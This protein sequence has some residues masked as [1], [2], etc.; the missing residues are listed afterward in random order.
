[1]N[2]ADYIGKTF[3]RLR[4]LSIADQAT[5]KGKNRKVTCL[6]VCG[7]IIETILPKLKTGH[8]KSCG[9]QRVSAN[10]IKS[11]KHGMSKHALDGVYSAMRARC[12]NKNNVAYKNYGGRGISVCEEWQMDRNNFFTWAL[13]NGWVHGLHLDRRDNDGGY[14]PDNCRFIT[15]TENNRNKKRKLKSV[16]I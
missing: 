7:K 15:Q 11:T 14:S 6:C 5:A 13:N 12:E 2:D 3:N 16:N 4:I 9:C 1:M 10:K 8:T